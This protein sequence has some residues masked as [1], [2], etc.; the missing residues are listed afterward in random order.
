[1]RDAEFQSDGTVVEEKTGKVEGRLKANVENGTE[2][3]NLLKSY[4]HIS[5]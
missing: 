2:K 5:I 3:D 4:Q 1:M